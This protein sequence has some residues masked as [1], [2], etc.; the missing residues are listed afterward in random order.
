[1][2]QGYH[3]A[4]M[5]AVTTAGIE[6]R[7]PGPLGAAWRTALAR[8]D[9]ARSSTRLWQRD[10]GL[11]TG[12]SEARWLGWLVPGAG[13]DPAELAALS[14]QVVAR[15]VRSVVLIGMGGSSLGAEVVARALRRPGAP[16]LIVLDTTDPDEIRGV[17]DT[18]D[19]ARS[20]FI[21]ASKSGT[22]LESVSLEEYFWSRLVA[23]PA[24]AASFVAI[25]DPG[26][27]LE[28]RARERGYRLFHGVPEVGGRFSALSPFGLVPA[29]AVG[30]DVESVLRSARGAATRARPEV[31]AAESPGIALGPL[32]ATLA[33]AGH[34]KLT[35]FPPP[36]IDLLGPWLEQLI[37]ESTGKAGK[38]ILPIAGEERLEL[39]AYRRDRALVHWD[40]ASGA[41]GDDQSAA[42]AEAAVVPVVRLPPAGAADL[43]GE[44]F[45]WELATA[46][47]G[48]LLGIDPFDQPD[49]DAAKIAARRLVA[50]SREGLVEPRG[51]RLLDAREW[52]WYGASPAL[53]ARPARVV[54]PVSDHQGSG[55]PAEILRAHLG[56]LGPGDFFALLGYLPRGGAVESELRRARQAVA[57]RRRVA[58]SLG[59]GPRYLHST[60]QYF[61]GGPDRGVYLFVTRLLADDLPI[62]GQDIGF[63]ALQRAQALG[64]IEV[65]IER[66]RRVLH[67]E[68]QEDVELGVERLRSLFETVL[69]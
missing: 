33:Q 19:L 60:G 28:A 63:G 10:A 47:A 41:A 67:V 58:T 2:P 26:N 13:C 32:L 11:W 46:V 42:A 3:S 39:A 4:P 57:A 22:T 50:A 7:M 29:A 14:R 43:G 15:G 1:M 52:R 44:I 34:D 38:G 66:G 25:T 36:E 12:G 37:A 6:A 54:T 16:E 18:L 5:T 48:S 20:L 51:E 61:K 62:P 68:L 23:D 59:F 21:V 8:W 31:A 9:A 30:G 55:A 40:S 64:D 24:R 27:S 49:V 45:R 56:S 69:S 35:L 17:D 65:L 53:R